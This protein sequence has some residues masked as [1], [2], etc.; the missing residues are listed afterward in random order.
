VKVNQY[1]AILRKA[2]ST[3]ARTKHFEFEVNGGERFEFVPGQ[4]ITIDVEIDG[5]DCA[6]SYS[7][8]SAPRPD[9]SF[10]LCLNLIP[11][12]IITPWLFNLKAGDRIQFTGPSGHFHLRQPVDPVSAFIA[13]GTGIAPIRAMLQELHTRP[14]SGEVWLIFGVRTQADILY[15][16]E[17]EKF[18]Q[19]DPNFHF[20]P[21][22]SRPRAG[23][24]GE[25][26]HVQGP[27]AKYLAG[28]QG[29]HAYIC[30]AGKMVEEVRRLLRSMGYD[31][32]ALSSERFD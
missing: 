30:G 11:G 13:T 29:F 7:V 31:S 15:R 22:V 23:W 20:V 6:R 19:D 26:G 17:F 18:T 24:A 10:E 8:A 14:L 1:E 9:N 32:A 27:I 3:N 28:R 16:E 2:W 5:E 4:Y 12:G 21:V 25:T